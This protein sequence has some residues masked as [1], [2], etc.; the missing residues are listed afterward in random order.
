MA[1]IGLALRCGFSVYRPFQIPSRTKPCLD[2]GKFAQEWER[3]DVVTVHKKSNKQLVKNN[4][5][6]PWYLYAVN[7]LNVYFTIPCLI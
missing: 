2:R 6:S 5:L 3:T 1:M 4:R 7:F